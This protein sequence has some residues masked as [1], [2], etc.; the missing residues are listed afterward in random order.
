MLEGIKNL[1]NQKKDFIESASIIMEEADTLNIDDSIVLGEA[2]ENIDVNDLDVSDEVLTE[3]GEEVESLNEEDDVDDNTIEDEED[4]KDDESEDPLN[5][6]VDSPIPSSDDDSLDDSNPEPE[7]PESDDVLDTDIDSELPTPVGAQTGQTVELPLQDLLNTEIDLQSNTSND[8]LPVPPTSASDAINSDELLD[9]N[10]D[11]GFGGEDSAKSTSEGEGDD[12]LNASIDDS[13]S[14]DNDLSLEESFVLILKECKEI[15]NDLDSTEEEVTEATRLAKEI[16][17]ASAKSEKISKL[18]D[19]LADKIKNTSDDNTK[20]IYTDQL[21]KL[22]DEEKKLNSKFKISTRAKRNNLKNLDTI[23]NQNKKG[24]NPDWYNKVSGDGASAKYGQRVK[25]DTEPAK[26]KEPNRYLDMQNMKRE[27]K[28]LTESFDDILDDFYDKYPDI[29]TEAISID[30]SGSED[31]SGS[32][33]AGASEEN[34]V[35]QEVKDNVAET[36]DGSTEDEGMDDP[37]MAAPDMSGS[38]NVE[39]LKKLNNITKSLEDA[40]NSIISGM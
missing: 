2:S 38:S 13:G 32:A 1:I 25:Y 19:Q 17:K 37:D 29:Y 23:G 31:S 8:I 3:D 27:I 33:D 16:H 10:V 22:S 18:K 34:D 12:L 36:D 35:T 11:S 28:K 14:E 20:K 15:I 7:V 6:E 30:D 39:L 4:T 40:K 5:D 24:V 26:N 21:D 9:S